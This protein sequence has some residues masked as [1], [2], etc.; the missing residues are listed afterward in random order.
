[1]KYITFSFFGG[2]TN[3]IGRGP[4]TRDSK[5]KNYTVAQ[6][7]IPLSHC[8]HPFWFLECQPCGPR[9][10]LLCFAIMANQ[11]SMTKLQNDMVESDPTYVPSEGFMMRKTGLQLALA[12]IG[13]C[14]HSIILNR[15]FLVCLVLNRAQSSRGNFGTRF[16]SSLSCFGK[17]ILFWKVPGRC[18][19]SLGM[20][21]VSWATGSRFD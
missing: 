15:I 5:K 8:W 3:Q 6:L 9:Q 4:S 13:F 20:G 18:S 11:W 1:M 10:A 16:K 2:A 21:Y 19:S 14:Y 17:C 7:P 12:I